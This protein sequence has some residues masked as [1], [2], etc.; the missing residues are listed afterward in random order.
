MVGPSPARNWLIPIIGLLAIT[1]TICTS[2]LVISGLLPTL[3]HDLGVDI[4]TAG[5]LITGYAIGVAIAGPLLSIAT[6]SVQRKTLLLAIVAVF[7]VGNILCALSSGYWMLLA[8][9]LIMSSCHGLYFGVAIVLAGR[10]APEGR[11]SFAVSVVVA[12][13]TTAISVG[14]PIGTAIGNA[15]GWRTTF[16][17]TAGAGALAALTVAW[18]IP[19]RGSL[20]PPHD[21][22]A[23]LRAA[24]RPVVLLCYVN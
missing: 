11:Q 16:W 6:G 20:E 14:V 21:L 1:F 3:A 10:L 4:P 8:A 24:V 12:G 13:V 15:C 9:R 23:E 17:V 7:I 2:E 18:L 22:K 5:F 19:G